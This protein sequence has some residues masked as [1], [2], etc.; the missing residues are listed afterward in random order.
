MRR[1]GTMV[2]LWVVP[3]WPVLGRYVPRVDP[4]MA[5]VLDGYPPPRAL[6][7]RSVI[8]ASTGLWLLTIDLTRWLEKG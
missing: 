7:L 4:F 6:A 8:L 2:F 3:L 5:K 1:P